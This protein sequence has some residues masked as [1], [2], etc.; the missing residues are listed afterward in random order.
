[1]SKEATPVSFSVMNGE[2]EIFI[3]QKKKYHI[4]PM[5]VSD[6]MKFSDENLSVGAQIFNLASKENRE[7][8]NYYLSKYCTNEEGELMSLD[9][10]I[11]ADWDIAELK[12][13]IRRLCD[14]SG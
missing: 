14:I 1:M 10:V 12:S 13:F 4:E 6:A 2:P 9:S 5:K 3:A 7:K 8:L 11:K